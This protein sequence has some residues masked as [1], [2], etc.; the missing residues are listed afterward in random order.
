MN[1]R[2]HD[3][4]PAPAKLPGIPDFSRSEA[5]AEDIADDHPIAADRRRASRWSSL[6]QLLPLVVAL[7]GVAFAVL[8]PA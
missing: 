2:A 6:L 5:F 7:V 1:L 4:C 8:P 3:P